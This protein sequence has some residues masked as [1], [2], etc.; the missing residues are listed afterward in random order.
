MPLEFQSCLTNS[1]SNLMPWMQRKEFQQIS[2]QELLQHSIVFTL[3]YFNELNQCCYFINCCYWLLFSFFFGV[4]N[5]FIFLF[6]G[7][8]PLFA[9]FLGSIVTILFYF[10]D[11][12]LFFC[13]FLS[14]IAVV[15]LFQGLQL[16]FAIFLS[17]IVVVFFFGVCNNYLLF[18]QVL[19]SL[20]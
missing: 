5:C 19:Q 14:F 13:Y 10:F 2:F 4:Y 6:F 20:F 17:S 11:L 15:L 8:Q 16:L 9:V 7:F 1:M 3:L 12:Q 18:F